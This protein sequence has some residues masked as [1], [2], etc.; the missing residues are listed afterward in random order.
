MKYTTIISPDALGELEQAY[1][2]LLERTP[3]YAPR[4]HD[5]L[6]EALISLE[7]NPLR[8]PI[9]HRDEESKEE[10]HQLLFG[11]KHHAYRILFVIRGQNVWIGHIVHSARG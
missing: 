5:E 9:S 1:Q 11:D 3:Q 10:Y 7:E 8:C 6:I 4:W 2:W